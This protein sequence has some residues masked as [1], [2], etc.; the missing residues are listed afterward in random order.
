[1]CSYTIIFSLAV[2]IDAIG[3]DSADFGELTS[4]TS[5]LENIIFRKLNEWVYSLPL[6]ILP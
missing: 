5:E 6:K 4:D 1:M 2:L 3:L